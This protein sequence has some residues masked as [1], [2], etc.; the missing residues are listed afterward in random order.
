MP[1]SVADKATTEDSDAPRKALPDSKLPRTPELSE[2]Q[3]RDTQ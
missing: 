1:K 2:T 3:S